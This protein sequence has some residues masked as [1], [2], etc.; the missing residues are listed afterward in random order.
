MLRWSW[1]AALLAFCACS[2]GAKKPPSSAE[3]EQI[4]QEGKALNAAA[5]QLEARMLEDQARVHLWQVL[6]RRHRHV[7]ALATVNADMH[8]KGM[9]KWLK[10]Q[11]RRW[12]AL[13]HVRVTGASHP[14]ARRGHTR[15]RRRH[16][17]HRRR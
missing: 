4:R 10:S 14:R 8:I 17:H 3:L 5:D 13:H 6:A 15:R 9:L 12:N 11:N 2:S 1:M 16:P 7:S